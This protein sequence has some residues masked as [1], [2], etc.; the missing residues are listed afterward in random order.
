[1]SPRLIPEPVGLE[2]LSEFRAS[3]VG[4]V[5]AEVVATAVRFGLQVLAERAPGRSVELRIPPYGATQV[6]GGTRHTRGTPP[7]VVEMRPETFLQLATGTITWD[8]AVDRGLVQ[9]SGNRSDLGGFFPLWQ[10]G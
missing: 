8:D 4:G 10:L 7:A 1:M 3:G 5:S 2:A 9:A 6:V